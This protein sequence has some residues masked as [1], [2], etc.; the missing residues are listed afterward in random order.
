[1]HGARSRT[2]E[3]QPVEAPVMLAIGQKHH[4]AY[5]RCCGRL[6][7]NGAGSRTAGSMCLR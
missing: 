3:E 2:I 4:S 1:M 6:A 5:A 7:I